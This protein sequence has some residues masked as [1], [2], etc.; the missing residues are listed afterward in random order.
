M[1]A[2]VTVNPA[3]DRI[4]YVDAFSVNQLHRIENRGQSKTL[5]G[6]K[7]VNVSV[8]LKILGISSIAM[9]FSG[10][11]LGAKFELELRLAG[12]TTNFVRTE[13]DTRTNLFII[14]ETN[15]QLT[16]IDV[17]GNPVS[18]ADMTIFL[19]RYAKILHQVDK[20]VLAG[21]LLPGMKPGFY[22]QLLRLANQRGIKTVIHAEP[23]Y[24][25]EALEEGAY[26]VFPDMRGTGEFNGQPLRS[27]EDCLAA[28]KRLLAKKE[29]NQII[30]FSHLIEQVVAV[31]REK[32]YVFGMKTPHKANLLGF[33]DALVAGTLCGLES[34]KSLKDALCQGCA[35]GYTVMEKREKFNFSAEAVTKK[36][37]DIETREMDL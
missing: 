17:N 27:V 33:G 15:D 5:I 37:S 31:T 24:L 34:G 11:V 19:D 32:A 26:L 10:G 13:Q 28:G 8:M 23:K 12:I 22:G 6:G 20:V 1:I 16:V 9:G 21:S 36:M 18:E 29:K 25:Q 14:D 35:A 7:G 4:C 2:T 30:L 3:F